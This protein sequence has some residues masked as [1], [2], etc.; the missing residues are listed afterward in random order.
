MTKQHGLGTLKKKAFDQVSGSQRVRI[1]GGGAKAWWQSGCSSYLG[2]QV[3]LAKTQCRKHSN[4]VPT[5]QASGFWSLESSLYIHQHLLLGLGHSRS[6]RIS[7]YSPIII[8]LQSQGTPASLL[9]TLSY[10]DASRMKR[11]AARETHRDSH[12]P[13]K[14]PQFNMVALL[15]TQQQMWCL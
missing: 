12:Y 14:H 7:L 9:E 11:E 13:N 4:Q 8:M 2:P 5:A 10:P 6:G 15:G 3:E 1:H